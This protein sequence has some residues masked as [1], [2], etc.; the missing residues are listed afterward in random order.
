MGVVVVGEVVVVVAVMVAVLAAT[1][2]RHTKK[3]L[4]SAV[5][6]KTHNKT[7]PD[8]TADRQQIRVCVVFVA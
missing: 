3:S 1:R 4:Y 6:K 2:V 5:K 7:F 8:N